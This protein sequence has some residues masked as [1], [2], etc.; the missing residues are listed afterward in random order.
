MP[1]VLIEAQ[2]SGLPCVIADTFSHE[3]DFGLNQIHWVPLKTG[4]A[5]W[6]DAVEKAV[7]TER[8]DKSEV[9]DAIEAKGFD[10]RIFARKLC[11]LY[12]AACHNMV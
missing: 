3:V 10:S 8:K 9:A 2:A 7:D 4:I 6:A 1:L 5:V 11:Q 12:Q